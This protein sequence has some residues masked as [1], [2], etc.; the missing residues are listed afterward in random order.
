MTFSTYTRQRLTES[1]RT[2]E[3]LRERA[4]RSGLLVILPPRPIE[5]Q[6][7]VILALSGYRVTVAEQELFAWVVLEMIVSTHVDHRGSLSLRRRGALPR[8]REHLAADFQ[9]LAE[10]ILQQKSAVK[11][12]AIPRLWNYLITGP[13]STSQWPTFFCSQS[14]SL[15]QTFPTPRP[16]S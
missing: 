13:P 2:H 1:V 15:Y 9:T 7:S 10:R 14:G 16:L 3:S 11:K 5:A 6:V 12:I 8:V 4:A